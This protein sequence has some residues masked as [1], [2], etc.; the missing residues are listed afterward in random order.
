MAENSE[1]P[2]VK[3]SKKVDGDGRMVISKEHRQA[4]GMDGR[5]CLIDF[6]AEIQHVL[7]EEEESA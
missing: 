1:T 5:D 6:E 4:L 3:F 7:E 2:T